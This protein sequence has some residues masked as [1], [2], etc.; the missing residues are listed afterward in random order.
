MKLGTYVVAPEPISAAY[1]INPCVCMCISPVF[2]RHR[3]CK[4]VSAAKN[5][6][7]K[8][9]WTC[10]FLCGQCR[11]EGESV[12]LCIPLSLQGSGSVNTF[13]WQWRIVGGVIFYAVRVVSKES[14]RLILPKTS[15]S[16]GEERWKWKDTPAGRTLLCSHLSF[17]T[18]HAT[19][20]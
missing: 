18:G 17:A 15:C 19:L 12:D 13:P 8:N 2:A 1:F 4:H 7:N 6:L 10:S 5:T 3:L 14:R 11:I 20:D 16:K 9:C